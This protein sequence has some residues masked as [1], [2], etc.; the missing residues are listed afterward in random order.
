MGRRWLVGHAAELDDRGSGRSAHSE[1]HGEVGVGGD[2]GVVV[3][4]RPFEY[5]HVGG[6]KQADVADVNCLVSLGAQR[7]RD[8][9]C[10]VAS[11]SSFTPGGRPGLRV[12]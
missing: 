12:R 9:R 4:V 6:R 2:H 7:G 3:L 5:S 10:Q 8:S 11:M 1:H